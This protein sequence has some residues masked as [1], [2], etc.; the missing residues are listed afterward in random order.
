MEDDSSVVI[1]DQSV[2]RV[3]PDHIKGPVLLG[4]LGHPYLVNDMGEHVVMLSPPLE[5]VFFY[6]P[7]VHCHI[8]VAIQHPRST[9]P[10]SQC[11]RISVA[12]EIHFLKHQIMDLSHLTSLTVV[13]CYSTKTWSLSQIKPAGINGFDSRPL[14]TVLDFTL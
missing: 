3:L 14:R 1:A 2:D 11:H 6:Q 5:F 10:G 4:A 7:L 12:K 8:K 13:L 9:R